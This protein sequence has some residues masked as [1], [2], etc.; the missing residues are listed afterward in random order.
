[1]ATR[2][3]KPRE[4]EREAKAPKRAREL[5]AASGWRLFARRAERAVQQ[6]I[7]GREGP[8][9]AP[10]GEAPEEEAKPSAEP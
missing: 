9:V 3:P 1:M 10:V 5:D 7:E 2:L 6:A 4:A 8:M